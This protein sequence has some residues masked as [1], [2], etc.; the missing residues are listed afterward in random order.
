MLVIMVML[1]KLLSIKLVAILK[2]S[3]RDDDVD[4]NAHDLGEYSVDGDRVDGGGNDVTDGNG[5][6][7]CIGDHVVGHNVDDDDDVDDKVNDIGNDPVGDDVG[8]DDGVGD[9]RDDHV[10]GVD[11]G[12][13]EDVV[14]CFWG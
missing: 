14:F 9:L 2:K 7:D 11:D 3:A 1:T 8:D 13:E 12:D 10:D 5:K 6:E 4:A